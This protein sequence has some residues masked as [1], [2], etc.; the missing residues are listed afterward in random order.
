[1]KYEFQCA[2]C[3]SIT[4]ATASWKELDDLK[5]EGVACACGQTAAYRFDARSVSVS[6]AGDAWADKNYKEKQYRK[7]R[8]SYMDAR[9]RSNNFSP[10]L[11]PNY[12]GQ[13]T[14]SWKE[15][16]EVARSQGKVAET[17]EPLV[18]KERR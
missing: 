15:A 17:Y 14:G 5:R 2:S 13:E 11:K 10:T 1:M 7:E 16:Q 4:T 3:G 6:F 8:A 12:M 18:R 9:Q